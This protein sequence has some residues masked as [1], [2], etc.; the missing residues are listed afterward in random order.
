MEIQHFSHDHPLALQETESLPPAYCSGCELPISAP[1]YGCAKCYFFLHKACTELPTELNQLHIFHPVHLLTLLPQ[2]PDNLTSFKCYVCGKTR[3]GFTYHCSPCQFDLCINC[4]LLIPPSEDKEYPEFRDPTHEHPFILCPKKREFQLPCIGCNQP[5]ED[6][7]LYLCPICLLFFHKSCADPSRELNHPFH[8]QHA[9][10]LL[11]YT[12]DGNLVSFR[13]KA[14]GRNGCNRVFH[15]A[16]CNFNMHVTCSIIIPTVKSSLHQHPLAFFRY[17]IRISLRCN[18]CEEILDEPYFRCVD[19]DFGLH[20]RCFPSL[21]FSVKSSRHRHALTITDSPIIDYVDKDD[22]EEF[23]CDACEQRRNLYARSYYCAEP[24]CHFV[25]HL[26][27]VISE[28]LHLLEEEWSLVREHRD[29]LEM[30]DIV[31]NNNDGEGVIS[32]LIEQPHAGFEE[33]KNLTLAE[34]D[35]EIAKLRMEIEA[36]TAKLGAFERRR[37][38]VAE[39]TI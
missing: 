2:P 27:C 26:E 39:S 16:K 24:G 18:S 29:E 13:C 34:L 8:P 28:V 4:I 23:Y 11:Y 1:F 37:A 14:C 15:C 10:T 35:E 17:Y 9:L 32:S 38:E 20:L 21:P 33:L 36:L 22:D 5:I 7:S 30:S 3:R 25:A 31:N 6:D 19:C 12:P